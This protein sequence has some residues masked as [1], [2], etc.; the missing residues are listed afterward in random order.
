MKPPFKFSAHTR[1]GFSDTDAQGIVYY[2]R[3]NPYF[4]LARV[5]YLRSLG[6]LHE[7]PGGGDFVMRA[8][9]VEYFAPAVFDDE[10][11]V[12][13]RVARLGRTSVTF[14]FAA[15][16]LPDD[17]LMVTAHQTLVYVDL[18]QRHAHE[19]PAAFRDRVLAFE[20]DDVEG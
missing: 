8:N 9:D 5:E 12:W 6:L 16:R 17:L 18:A 2:G 10:I 13:T 14:A 3:Y 11:E 19:V 7:G 4:D 1:V 20:G 15:Y